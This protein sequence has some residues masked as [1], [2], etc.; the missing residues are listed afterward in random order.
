[1]RDQRGR[2]QGEG[3]E[4][5]LKGAF[6]GNEGGP[7]GA[8]VQNLVEWRAGGAFETEA[9]NGVDDHICLLLEGTGGQVL[10][11]QERDVQ[12]LELSHQA[13]VQ[14]LVCL[15]GIAHLRTRKRHA[16][17]AEHA[18]VKPSTSELM[19][20]RSWQLEKLLFS[21]DLWKCNSRL[22]C[23]ASCGGTNTKS[24]PCRSPDGGT[25]H[26]MRRASHAPLER[27]LTVLHPRTYLQQTKC[28]FCTAAAFPS[29]GIRM[30]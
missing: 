6:S 12:R 22:K 28:H 11:R 7:T 13:M 9:K 14:R 26:E 17:I 24:S 20:S 16:E 4:W 27:P 3:E 5:I 21:M 30:P 23:W 1:M 18:F 10:C 25:V 2:G 8:H 19:S 15:L 29:P